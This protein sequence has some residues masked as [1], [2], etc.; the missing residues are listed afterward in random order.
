MCTGLR[1]WKV[2]IKMERMV[3]ALRLARTP[4][5]VCLWRVCPV[6]RTAQMISGQRPGS[7]PANE[8]GLAGIVGDKGWRKKRAAVASKGA[9]EAIQR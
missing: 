4:G 3:M 2:A 6:H 9:E 8:T 1:Q 5:R 7:S